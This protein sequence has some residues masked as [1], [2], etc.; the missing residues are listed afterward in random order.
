MLSS[1]SVDRI[2]SSV[3]VA[4]PLYV[5][6]SAIAT[7]NGDTNR[8][9]RV[10]RSSLYVSRS[11]LIAKRLSAW[12]SCC[13]CAVSARGKAVMRGGALGLTGSLLQAI[14]TSS[15][16]IAGRRPD[17]MTVSLCRRYPRDCRGRHYGA[18]ATRGYAG[19]RLLHRTPH[20]TTLRPA[21]NAHAIRPA[22]RP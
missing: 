6:P 2:A 16:A 5:M 21:G 11:S 22:A 7:D 15:R 3:V 19:R 17:L 20:W 9:G 14:T 13:S 12:I 18:V 8:L 1:S 10:S 4:A